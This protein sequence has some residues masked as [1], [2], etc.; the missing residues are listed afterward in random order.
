MSA[1]EVDVGQ[2]S[3]P[4]ALIAYD[5]VDARQQYDRLLEV[6]R[7]AA[8]ELDAFL[9]GGIPD[10]RD[11]QAPRLQREARRRVNS[12]VWA[13][14][15]LRRAAERVCDVEELPDD[16]KAENIIWEVDL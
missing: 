9:N 11:P 8:R 15:A 6:A 10:L 16:G 13:S 4:E 1:H 12:Y 14:L 3:G 7:G 2:L 5:R